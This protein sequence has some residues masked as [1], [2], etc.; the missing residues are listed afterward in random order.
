MAMAIVRVRKGKASGAAYAVYSGRQP[1]TFG[2]GEECD[3]QLDDDRA[4]RKHARILL[5]FGSWVVQD[6]GSSNG[7]LVRGKPVDKARLEAETPIQ[8]GNTLLTFHPDEFAPPPE[9]EVF[10]TRPLECLREESSVIVTKAYQAAFDREVRVEQL[11]AGRTLTPETLDALRRAIDGDE[12]S[13]AVSSLQ[14]GRID[15]FVHGDVDAKLPYVI[16]RSGSGELLS[17]RLESLLREDLPVRLAVFRQVADALLARDEH[18]WL[19]AAFSTHQVRLWMDDEGYVQ[20]SIA[21]VDLA[22]LASGWGGNLPHLD[23]YVPYLAPELGDGQPLEGPLD[24]AASAYGLGAFGYHLLTGSPPMGAGGTRQILANH[25]SLAPAS[26]S[27]V[28]VD[29]PDE[30]S[31]LLDSLLAKEPAD[32]P[33]HRGEILG[34]LDSV[35]TSPALA[36]RDL[37]AST[38]AARTA[39]PRPTAKPAPRPPRTTVRDGNGRPARSD[40]AP[41]VTATAEPEESAVGLAR[42]ILT[43]PLWIIVWTALFFGGRVLSK[44]LFEAFMP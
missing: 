23:A 3:A 42:Q 31:R 13:G 28:E 38:P 7:T 30:I 40:P 29:L 12:G 24:A 6:L 19:R 36:S 44:V 35:D 18:P 26:A 21:A 8:I 34:I 1:T 5:A 14:H 15:A 22:A 43:L 25:Q 32:R 16:V 27:L 2:R 9:R 11:A 39:S 20:T 41:R 33:T 4:S 37:E 17:T 10:G